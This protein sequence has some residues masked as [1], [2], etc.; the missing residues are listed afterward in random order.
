M[1][2]EPS[3][4]DRKLISPQAERTTSR[5]VTRAEVGGIVDLERYRIADPDSP[6][7]RS[8]VERCRAAIREDGH[9]LLPGFL[10]PDSTRTMVEEADPLLPGAWFCSRTHN[11]YLAPEDR[12]FPEGHPRRRRLTTRVG[13]LAHDRLP[14]EGLLCRLYDWDPL[15]RFV[16]A[17]LEKQAFYRLADPLGALSINVF[18]DG[19]GHAW[20]FDESE[21]SMTIMLQTAE[22]GG[23]FECVPR[24]R[25][26]E[27]ED[28]DAV[29]RVLDG[30]VDD[31][32]RLEFEPGTLLIF[33]GRRSI[34][35]V[36]A[37][38]SGRPR[39]VAVLCYGSE[40]GLINSDLVRELFWGRT[41]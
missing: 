23:H 20:H 27:G 18:T 30:Q 29:G 22:R 11:V 12:G 39:L 41:G 32:R 34:H 13:S 28:Y 37:I 33:G 25:P 21:F 9:C 1:S 8:L 15:V 35:R 4:H 36:T 19:G 14:K 24:I 26:A 6:G 2:P 16:G 7:S 17:V 3:P 38:R 40:P 5:E 31:V 10:T